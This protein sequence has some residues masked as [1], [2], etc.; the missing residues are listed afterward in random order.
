MCRKMFT[1]VLCI[2]PFLSLIFQFVQSFNIFC[3]APLKELHPYIQ[4]HISGVSMKWNCEANT[5]ENVNVLVVGGCTW[6]PH[7]E[8]LVRRCSFSRGRKKEVTHL[9]ECNCFEDDKSPSHEKW[10]LRR[11][12][13]SNVVHHFIRSDLHC[14]HHSMCVAVD[15]VFWCVVV[16]TWI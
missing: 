3:I 5:N 1:T 12:P 9:C 6:N 16:P 14:H 11:Q 2:L 4:P 7:N 8:S 13:L 15:Y 10:D